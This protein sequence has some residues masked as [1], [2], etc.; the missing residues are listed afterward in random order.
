[1]QRSDDSPSLYTK[2]IESEAKY[3]RWY[4][5]VVYQ[6]DLKLKRSGNTSFSNLRP[7]AVRWEEDIW[8]SGLD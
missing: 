2:I 5:V 8:A 6:D 3:K 1:M 4:H 7:V